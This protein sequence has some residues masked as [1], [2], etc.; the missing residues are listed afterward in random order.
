MMDAMSK[1]AGS[2][3]V[4]KIKAQGPGLMW[5]LRNR[6]RW[7][8]IWGFIAYHMAFL[9]ARVLG[10]TSVV[11]KLD[12]MV[13]KANGRRIHYGTVGYRVVTTAGVNAMATAFITPASPGNFY[14]HGIGHTNTAE[15]VGDTTLAAEETT[16]Y[17]PDSTR[18][19]GT[20]VQGASANIYQSVATNTVDGAV[21]CVEHGI[22][23]AASSGTL[24]DRTVF[25][26]VTLASGDGLQSTYNLTF[27]AGG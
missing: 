14:Y 25:S 26:T 3:A 16:A 18:A 13:I 6:I 8:F 20:H 10:F 11:S 19:T 21:S 23:S 27:T 1:P 15:A 5:H 22:F 7:G 17:N 9:C 12:L 2:L 24:L 4:R